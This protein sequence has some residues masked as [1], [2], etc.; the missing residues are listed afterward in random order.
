MEIK[1]FEESYFLMIEDMSGSTISNIDIKLKD[2]DA[3]PEDQKEALM[4]KITNKAKSKAK[5]KFKNYLK[6]KD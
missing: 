6:K 4:E 5:N 2:I 3:V 1:E